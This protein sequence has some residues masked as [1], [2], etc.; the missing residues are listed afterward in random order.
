MICGVTGLTGGV[1]LVTR[2]C[3]CPHPAVSH[4]YSPDAA[5]AARKPPIL[6]SRVNN[7]EEV[8]YRRSL[9]SSGDAM[10]QW[11]NIP[12]PLRLEWTG[13]LELKSSRG[14]NA[15]VSTYFDHRSNCEGGGW[16]RDG[17]ITAAA[18]QNNLGVGPGLPAKFA[19]KTKYTFYITS[20]L[21]SLQRNPFLYYP[22]NL[23]INS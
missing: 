5:E 8:P 12:T 9:F 16:K 15:A 7:G 13:T 1:T 19:I 20:L 22:W 21:R 17:R 2:P 6:I 3:D 10:Q 4:I 14:T 11:C 23:L 18:P